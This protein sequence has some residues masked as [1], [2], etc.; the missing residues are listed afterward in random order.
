MTTPTI[1]PKVE[2]G[3]RVMFTRYS[4]L[5]KPGRPETPGVITGLMPE[6]GASVRLRLDGRRSSLYVRPDFEGLRYLDETGP[7]PEL[8]M[9]RFRPTPDDLEGV[10]EGVPV[11][12]ISEDGDIVLLTLDREQAV[13]AATAYLTDAWVD[14]DFV[15]WDDLVLRWAYFEWQPEDSDMAW[16]MHWCDQGDDQAIQLYYLPA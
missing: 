12:S 5:G 15:H 3:R 4:D 7:V 14:L 8:P 11:C 2:P 10:W 16:F 13:K 1:H 6:Q 9:G